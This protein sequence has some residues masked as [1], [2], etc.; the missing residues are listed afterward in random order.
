[1]LVGADLPGGTHSTEEMGVREE[2]RDRVERR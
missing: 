1:V 2:G